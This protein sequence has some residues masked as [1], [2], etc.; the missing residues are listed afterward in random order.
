MPCWARRAPMVAAGPDRD[1]EHRGRLVGDDEAGAEHQGPGQG[2]PLALASGQLVGVAAG[3]LIGRSQARLGEGVE[4]PA[5]PVGLVD[6]VDDQRLAHQVRHPQAWAERL[7][8]VLEDQVHVAAG[9]PQL[10][11]PRPSQIST[12]EEHLAPVGPHQPQ[13]QAGHGRLARAAPADEPDGLTGVHG[14]V[15]P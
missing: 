13:R 5:V 9:D 15:D 4:H 2:H 11:L 10:A 7:V 3:E 1:V 12:V 14:E 8:G 6:A